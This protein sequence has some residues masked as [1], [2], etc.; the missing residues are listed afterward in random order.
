[1]EAGPFSEVTR[2]S[3]LLRPCT[4]R[5][6]GGRGG[7]SGGGELAGNL[8]CSCHPHCRTQFKEHVTVWEVKVED[9]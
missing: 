6:G 3:L 2:N 5:A 7:R 4:P 8:P 9:G 1:M